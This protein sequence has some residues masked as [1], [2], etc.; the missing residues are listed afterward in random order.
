MEKRI[1][2]YVKGQLSGQEAE[3]LWVQLLKRPDYIDLLETELVVKAIIEEELA[4]RAEDTKTT[5]LFGK[6]VRASWK[7]VAVAASIAI[8][9]ISLSLFTTD[10]QPAL[11]NMTLPEINMVE[12]LS[13]TPVF[14]S[15]KNNV[16]RADSLL[17]VGYKA[18][19]SGDIKRAV[20]IYNDIIRG[21]GDTP[22]AAKAHLN[23]GIIQYNNGRY[24]EAAGAFSRAA[25]G[26][27]N[28]AILEEKAY[29]Y[30]SNAYVNLG[31]FADAHEAVQKA[32]SMDGI[33]HNPAQRLLNRLSEKLKND[34][35]NN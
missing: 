26:V 15:Q 18:A 10:K 8:L 5:Y 30:L 23:L 31:R 29:W 21:Y 24:E 4:G 16:R 17:N 14:R 20:G 6:P 19:I 33:Y 25:G 2:A 1:D 28:D 3:T 12:N 27:R 9:V 13:S 11:Q 34:N 32:Y 7:W 22:A 35:N